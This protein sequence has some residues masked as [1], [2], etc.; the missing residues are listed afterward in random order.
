[1]RATHDHKAR[2]VLM[3]AREAK[4]HDISSD[5]LGSDACCPSGHTRNRLGSRKIKTCHSGIGETPAE[6]GQ[7]PTLAGCA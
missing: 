2:L 5:C 6:S 7:Q 3:H 4:F 1:M